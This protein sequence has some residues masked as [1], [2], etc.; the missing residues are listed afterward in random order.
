MKRRQFL[1]LAL[2]VPT[3]SATLTACAL[4]R[5]SDRGENN[6]ESE[7]VLPETERYSAA[8]SED[9]I[10]GISDTPSPA[11]QVIYSSLPVPGERCVW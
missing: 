5:P 8:P 9:V 10:Q 4:F 7:S 2:L 3:T 6:T 1:S 11:W